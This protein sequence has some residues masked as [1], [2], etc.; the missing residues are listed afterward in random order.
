[1]DTNKMFYND[2]YGI[3]PRRSTEL[4]TVRFVTDLL[5]DMNNYK[6]PTTVLIDLSKAFDTLNHDILLSKLRYCGV[7]G[8]ELRLLSNY[9]SDRVQYVKYLGTISQSKSFGVGVLPGFI[10]GPLLFLI[11]INDLP[12]SIDM[13]NILMYAEN[14]TL[15]CNFDTTC[16]SEKINFE[17]KKIYRGLCCNKLSLNVSKT[18]FACFEQHNKL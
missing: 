18:K 16:N 1:M 12:K 17:L 7:S 14:T 9:L 3:R 6:I 2:Q 15:F 11:Y 13:F 4:A 8:I 5:K 10:L